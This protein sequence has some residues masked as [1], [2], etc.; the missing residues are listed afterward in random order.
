MSMIKSKY[1]VVTINVLLL[2]FVLEVVLR[3]SPSIVPA[4]VLVHFNENIRSGAAKG[5]YITKDDVTLIKRDDGGPE[6]TTFRKYQKLNHTYDDKDSV[7][8]VMMDE[9][10]FCNPKGLYSSREKFDIISLGDSFTWCTAVAINDTFTYKLSRLL[11][12]STYNLGRPGVGLYEYIQFLKHFGLQKSPKYLLFNVYEG[13]DL[14]DAFTYLNY[15]DTIRL[16]KEKNFIDISI[17]FILKYSY[18]INMIVALVEAD[19]N[20]VKYFSSFT[21]KVDVSISASVELLEKNQQN[22]K[23][24]KKINRDFSY[25]IYLKDKY[26]Q[27]NPYASDL[28]ELRMAE[29]IFSNEGETYVFDKALKDLSGLSDK[30]KFKVI[31]IYIPSAYTAYRDSVVFSDKKLEKL[32]SVYSSILRKY[33]SKSSKE[34]G[35]YFLDLTTKLQNHHRTAKEQELMY[36]PS[37][38]H[39]TQYGHTIAAKAIAEFLSEKKILQQNE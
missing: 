17:D 34:Y 26:V 29:H 7:N 15:I 38:V 28:D 21:N 9:I 11:D 33:F 5:R 16:K 14:R 30:H 18:A 32:L 25:K 4:F 24:E 10:G 20:N 36:F 23:S 31:L 2:V 13:N 8:T 1:L 22:R 19:Y 12:N 37:N 6:L 3:M 35:F 27:L 39:F